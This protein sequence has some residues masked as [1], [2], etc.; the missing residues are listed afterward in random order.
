MQHELSPKRLERLKDPYIADEVK[1]I[2]FMTEIY[3]RKHHGSE[4]GQLCEDCK[5]FL[6]YATKRLACCP[7][8]A[9]KPVCKKCKI[10]CFQKEYKDKAKEIMSFSGPRLMARHP[11][12]SARHVVAMFRKALDK[13]KAPNRASDK[14]Q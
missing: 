1:T 8:G 3:C 11:I 14:T 12:L 2:Q 7:Y 9:E 6:A 10:H 13:P 4:S 5:D